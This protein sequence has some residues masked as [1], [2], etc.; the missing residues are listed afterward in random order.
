MWQRTHSPRL[1]SGTILFVAAV[2]WWFPSHADGQGFQGFDSSSLTPVTEAQGQWG[3]K[4]VVL[5]VGQAD[6]VLL[7]TP[8]GDVC[9][10]DSGR[11]STAGNRVVDYLSTKALNGVGTLKTIDVL[12]STHFDQ[13]HIGGLK[14]I[15]ERGIRI[16]KAF[17]QGLSAKRDQKTRYMEYVAAVGDA[18]NDLKQDA[19]ESNY[20]R[21][22]LDYGHVEYVGLEDE[23]EIRCVAVRG[24]TAGDA[25]DL[26]RD[27]STSDIDENPGSIAVRC[28]SPFSATVH[29]A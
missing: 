28:R 29:A 4:I 16:R 17:D 27:P 13:D 20:V 7:L 10:I 8:N 6:A 26:D 21:H 5:N 1:G 3:L 14:R 23:V 15:V 11:T 22:R 12:Y 25:H 18:D 9:L 24:D 2:F 19:D